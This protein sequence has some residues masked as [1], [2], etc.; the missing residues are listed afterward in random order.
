MSR[1]NSDLIT[2]RGDEPKIVRLDGVDRRLL[3]DLVDDARTPNNVLAGRA[4]VAPST[5]WARIRRLEEVGVIT[6]Y[7][8]EVNLGILGLGVHALLQLR[9][10][11]NARP[12]MLAVARSTARGGE[13]ARSLPRRRGS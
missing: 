12:R 5:A 2:D 6:G 9:V 10:Q 1:L 3:R 7:H 13:C 4:G 11:V 8:A